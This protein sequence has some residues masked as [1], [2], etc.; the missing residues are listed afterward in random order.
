MSTDQPTH[1]PITTDLAALRR[2]IHQHATE[3]GLTG[4]RLD[5]LLLAAN[6]AAANVVEHGGGSGTLSIWHDET[7]VTVDVVDTAGRLRPRDVHRR[8]PSTQT[9]RGFGLWL[10]GRLCDEFTVH[11]DTGRSRVRLRMRLHPRPVES[12]AVS[13]PVVPVSPSSAGRD[14]RARRRPAGAPARSDQSACG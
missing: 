13:F 14:R 9:G 11:Q 12:P 1:W 8:R 6:E 3:A 10:M 5:D 2:R 7:D 4:T